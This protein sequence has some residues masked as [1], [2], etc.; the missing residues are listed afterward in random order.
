MFPIIRQ[1]KGKMRVMRV[2]RVDG[3]TSWVVPF[4]GGQLRQ[5]IGDRVPTGAVQVHHP[6]LAF[7]ELRLGKP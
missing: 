3:L 5:P 2:I 6:L 7:G 4:H 1:G